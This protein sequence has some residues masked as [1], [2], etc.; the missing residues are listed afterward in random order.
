MENQLKATAMFKSGWETFK[1]NPVQHVLVIL[2]VST[3]AQIISM[4]LVRIDPVFGEMLHF[5][6]VGAFTGMFYVSYS[7]LQDRN[8]KM[9][10]TEIAKSVFDFEMWWKYLFVSIMV[11][12]ATMI[13]LVLLLVPGIILSLGLAF[14]RYLV[15]DYK[16]S[17]VDAIKKSWEITDGYKWNLLI[18]VF[19]TLLVNIAGSLALLVGLLIT[20]PVTMFAWAHAYNILTGGLALDA[21]QE[22]QEEETTEDMTETDEE[23]ND[24]ADDEADA[25]MSDSM[26]ESNG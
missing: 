4:L 6:T 9:S 18:L 3:I 20:V 24:E 13:G 22:Q 7:I 16:M 15:V 1:K 10:P 5:A 17:P 14:A 23:D 21:T 26:A 25:T 2:V 19:L 11:F 8:T 12:L